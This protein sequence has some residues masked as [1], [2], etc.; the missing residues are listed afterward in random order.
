M[1]CIQQISHHLHLTVHH[2]LHIISPAVPLCV[3][4]T[5][6]QTEVTLLNSFCRNYVNYS[7]PEATW[8][9]QLFTDLASYDLLK[10]QQQQRA[11]Y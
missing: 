4:N 11:A 1:N 7:K 10:K 5:S 9:T 8:V 2:V 3:L 6:G